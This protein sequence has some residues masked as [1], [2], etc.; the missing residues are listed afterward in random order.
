MKTV[1]VS[2]KRASFDSVS[3]GTLKTEDLL[4]ALG[5]ELEWLILRNGDFLSLPENFA[6]RDRLNK[7][8]GDAGDCFGKDG[9]TLTPEG[10]E[11]GSEIVNKLCDALTE[12][13]PLYGQ[14][15]THCGDGA[16][17]GYWTDLD[18]VKEQVGFVSHVDRE[19]PEAG[20]EGEWLHVNERGNCTLYVREGDVDREIWSIRLNRNTNP[21]T[22]E[23]LHC[24]TPPRSRNVSP[25]GNRNV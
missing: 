14:F 16:D 23:N 5:N 21:T 20:F 9:E 12:F 17:F 15:G 11:N 18:S 8:V 10:E 6:T 7:L 1:S 3:H 19:Y 4:N 13:A 24:H 25:K 22:H 2:L